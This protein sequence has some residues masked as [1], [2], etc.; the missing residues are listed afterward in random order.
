MVT[1]E[2]HLRADSE[3]DLLI[4]LPDEFL[5]KSFT[6]KVEEEPM[7]T[8][9]A[10]RQRLKETFALLDSLKI[11]TSGYEFDRNEANER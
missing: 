6:V 10:R 11:D 2:Q 4:K 5:N 9:E 8:D 7:D 3:S 1:F